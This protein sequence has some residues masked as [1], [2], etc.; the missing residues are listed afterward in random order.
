VN[1]ALYGYSIR[2]ESIRVP[3]PDAEACAESYEKFGSNTITGAGAIMDFILAT[4]FLSL[5][6][7][8]SI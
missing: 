3:Y 1:I 5:Y 7:K 4:P 8:S 6:L 2:E